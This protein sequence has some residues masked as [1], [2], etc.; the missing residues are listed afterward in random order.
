MYKGANNEK[1]KA[2]QDLTD[3]KPVNY[4]SEQNGFNFSLVPKT[5][6]MTR[7]QQY[8]FICVVDT[9][10]NKIK[11]FKLPSFEIDEEFGSFDLPKDCSEIKQLLLDDGAD[12]EGDHDKEEAHMRLFLLDTQ[13]RLYFREVTLKPVKFQ[14][15][16]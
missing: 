16:V 5:W 7:D 1:E 13:N 15:M 11:V 2:L 12:L 9:I 10:P 4:S 14:E 6:A 8:A 3:M